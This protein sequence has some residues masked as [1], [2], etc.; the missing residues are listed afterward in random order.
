MAKLPEPA[1]GFYLSR[2]VGG[3]LT[4]LEASLDSQG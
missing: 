3:G 1:T 4:S 2:K